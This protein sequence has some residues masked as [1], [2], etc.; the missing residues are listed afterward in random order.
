MATKK[1]APTPLPLPAKGGSYVLN[2]ETGEWVEP[3]AQAE[4]API[5]ENL[6]DSTD[7]TN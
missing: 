2:A 5:P 6:D 7:G 1:K 3:S 4:P